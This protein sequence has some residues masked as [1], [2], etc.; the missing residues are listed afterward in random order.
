MSNFVLHRSAAEI[1]LKDM[2]NVS[3]SQ[4][5]PFDRLLYLTFWNNYNDSNRKCITLSSFNLVNSFSL[6]S[7]TYG[8]GINF[9][10]TNDANNNRYLIRSRS[11][12]LAGTATRN[13]SF[14]YILISTTDVTSSG[15]TGLG[16]L[17]FDDSVTITSTQKLTIQQNSIIFEIPY[18]I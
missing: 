3:P 13:G 14:K 10:I 18:V 7:I 11:G 4:T 6:S 5:I 16:T 17:F 2:L 12:E 8:L 1:G 9:S 15:A